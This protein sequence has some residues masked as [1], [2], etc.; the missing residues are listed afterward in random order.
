MHGD[1]GSGHAP[2]GPRGNRPS[3]T[4]IVRRLPTPV[5]A[6]GCGLRD[7]AAIGRRRPR[8]HDP[9]GDP[10]LVSDGRVRSDR[11]ARP[12]PGRGSRSRRPAC[13]A[14]TEATRYARHAVTLSRADLAAAATARTR[15]ARPDARATAAS[16]CYAAASARRRAIAGVAGRGRPSSRTLPRRRGPYTMTLGDR[17]AVRRRGELRPRVERH[18]AILSRLVDDPGPDPFDAE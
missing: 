10:Q 9:C 3:A 2:E 6:S 14:P 17:V 18:R 16:P 8:R 4:E 1:H 5:S 12:G 13:A 15:S 7:A 11:T